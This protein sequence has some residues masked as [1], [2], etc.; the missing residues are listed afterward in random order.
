M[1]FVRPSQTVNI[2]VPLWSG[3]EM[4]TGKTVNVSIERH[5]DG[6]FWDG[7]S[8]ETS[9]GTVV[10]SELT[11]NVHN[12]GVYQ[13]A[14]AVPAGVAMYDWSVKYVEGALTTYF[15]GSISASYDGPTYAE[16][17]TQVQVGLASAYLDKLF[18]GGL[19]DDVAASTTAFDTTLFA[20]D[21]I[22]RDV[23]LLFI[24]GA[25]SGQ[26]TVVRTYVNANGRITVSPALSNAP[27]NNDAFLILQASFLDAKDRDSGR[28]LA[29]LNQSAPP[30]TPTVDEINMWL[31]TAWKNRKTQTA[32]EQV[33][34]EDD[35]A[36]ELTTAAITDDGTT[37]EVA[38]KVAGT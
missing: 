4:L 32:T 13:Y 31:Y 9:Y 7:D 15:K 16:V 8:F 5:S 33:L 35:N 2:R 21:G 6:K 37:A 11:G 3:S 19:V 14:F 38:K 23:T 10:M 34:F 25:N 20:T 1:E 17:L 28:T 18:A 27:A 26:S 24:G 22:Y 29:A 30:D 12:E 36:T